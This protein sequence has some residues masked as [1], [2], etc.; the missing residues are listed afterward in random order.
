MERVPPIHCG[1]SNRALPCAREIGLECRRTNV[2]HSQSVRIICPGVH[3][4][5][6][7]LRRAADS[8]A[9]SQKAKRTQPVDQKSLRENRLNYIGAV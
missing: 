1:A 9:N 2:R 7:Q 5:S 6:A 4:G 3:K 8:I